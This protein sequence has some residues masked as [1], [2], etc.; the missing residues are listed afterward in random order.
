[1]SKPGGTKGWNDLAA[2]LTEAQ[3]AYLRELVDEALDSG[4]S[5]S[6]FRDR[7]AGGEAAERREEA[8]LSRAEAARR[9][10]EMQSTMMRE[11]RDFFRRVRDR[12]ADQ[13]NQ[14][15][16]NGQP[17]HSDADRIGSISPK[18]EEEQ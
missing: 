3:R 9:A 15:P 14:G 18:G 1:M 16:Q 4:L 17:T 10:R 11:H 7:I 2:G 5:L 13:S 12:L 8:V 6:D